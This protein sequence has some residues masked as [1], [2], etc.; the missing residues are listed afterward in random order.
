MLTRSALVVFTAVMSAFA[1]SEGVARCEPKAPKPVVCL[2]WKAIPGNELVL[3][4][5]GNGK[6]RVLSNPITVKLELPDGSGKVVTAV[7]GWR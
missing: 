7:I 1:V 5:D 6:P 3:C 4:L 2:E